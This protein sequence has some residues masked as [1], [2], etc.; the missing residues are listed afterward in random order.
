MSADPLGRRVDDDVGAILDRPAQGRRAEG[1]VHH[2]RDSRR[3]G[4]FG[5]GGEVGDVEPW[6]ADR[7]D[8]EQPGALVNRLA[9]RIQVVD[10]HELRGDAPLGQSVGK[11]IVGA[12]VERLGG[13]QV[14]SGPGEVEDSE[15]LRR[16]S[17][18]Q[19]ECCDTALELR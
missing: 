1:V 5:Q 19:A 14:V 9:Y 18:S 3:M 13:H 4:D 2:E 16:L 12:P 6:I 8:E 10:V 15:R 11:E 7:L 17:A